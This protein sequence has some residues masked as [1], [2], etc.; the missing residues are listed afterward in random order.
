MSDPM[1]LGISA[2]DRRNERLT[3]IDRNNDGKI[4]RAEFNRMREKPSASSKDRIS[5]VEFISQQLSGTNNSAE[6]EF[7]RLL[8]TI[9]PGTNDQN[10]SKNLANAI[11]RTIVEGKH[12]NAGKIIFNFFINPSPANQRLL[13]NLLTVA[14]QSVLQEV[15]GNLLKDVDPATF[16]NLLI[17]HI[18]KDNGERSHYAAN[19]LA[20]MFQNAPAPTAQ[21][22]ENLYRDAGWTDLAGA[23]SERQNAINL[24]RQELAKIIDTHN[25]SPVSLAYQR[26]SNFINSYNPEYY[27]NNSSDFG[28]WRNTQSGNVAFFLQHLERAAAQGEAEFDKAW[29]SFDQ[30]LRFRIMNNK[31]YLLKFLDISKAYLPWGN[32]QGIYHTVLGGMRRRISSQTPDSD[33]LGQICRNVLSRGKQHEINELLGFMLE[34]KELC[35]PLLSKTENQEIFRQLLAQKTRTLTDIDYLFLRNFLNTEKDQEL[36][37]G[38]YE[39]HSYTTI[40]AAQLEELAQN[41]QNLKPPIQYP[42]R[43]S[44]IDILS[45]VVYT[46]QH[47][48]TG[49]TALILANQSDHNS[50]FSAYNY[51]FCQN[52]EALYAHGYEVCYYETNNDSE[53]F[54]QAFQNTYNCNPDAE[55]YPSE[56]LEHPIN[57]ILLAAHGF[58]FGMDFGSEAFRQEIA[59]LSP[60]DREQMWRNA[61]LGSAPSPVSQRLAALQDR[62]ILGRADSTKLEQYGSFCSDKLIIVD[63]SCR[64]GGAK[65]SLVDILADS[66]RGAKVLGDSL[67]IFGGNLVFDAEHNVTGILFYDTRDANGQMIGDPNTDKTVVYAKTNQRK[68]L[69]SAEIQSQIADRALW[70]KQ[71]KFSVYSS[72]NQAEF[73]TNFNDFGFRFSSAVNGGIQ[74]SLDYGILET[75][76]GQRIRDFTIAEQYIKELQIIERAEWLEIRAIYKEEYAALPD[77][78]FIARRQDENTPLNNH[79]LRGCFRKPLTRKEFNGL[80]ESVPKHQQRQDDNYRARTAYIRELLRASG[81]TAGQELLTL[82]RSMRLAG[83]DNN[84]STNLANALALVALDEDRNP[85][86]PHTSTAARDCLLTFL[87]NTQQNQREREMF[88]ANLNPRL[89]ERLNNR[90]LNRRK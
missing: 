84:Y 47:K 61:T 24:F 81:D 90:L 37:A 87:Q 31:D 70:P 12:E 72:K 89:R 17:V 32:P 21:A 5:R 7:K 25:N 73:L 65:V 76:D 23:V 74:L 2:Y 80:R 58:E 63:Y 26:L 64:T 15:L 1:N 54:L 67:D 20:V 69:D 60:A 75:A 55:D 45:K 38:L 43:F 59:T 28:I 53:G 56:P 34:I 14:D 51:L 41:C 46:R 85:D 83:G 13:N 27:Q 62:A 8:E 78:V 4:S 42:E 39:T 18:I 36:L 44:T 50:V 40:S 49:K 29:K 68:E 71:I 82:I 16:I 33:I 19:L 48:L 52:I 57:L 22:L 66:I 11:L 86:N 10:Y 30:H 88:L 79:S 6:Q 35:R 77:S 9:Q 3:N